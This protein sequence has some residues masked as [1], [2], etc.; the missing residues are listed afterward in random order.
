V[1]CYYL[2]VLTVL[3]KQSETIKVR[4]IP[5]GEEPKDSVNALVYEPAG[6]NW[7]FERPGGFWPKP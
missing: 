6:T 2:S 1:D 3:T 7:D 5:T 4:N